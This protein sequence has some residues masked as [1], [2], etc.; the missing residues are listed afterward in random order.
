MLNNAGCRKLRNEELHLYSP[1]NI[2]RV[3]KGKRMR[4]ASNLARMGVNV[5]EHKFLDRIVEG[6]RKL[7]RTDVKKIMIL[8]RILEK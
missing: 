8:K 7:G 1:T 3:M 4:L 6:K 5:N 2:I